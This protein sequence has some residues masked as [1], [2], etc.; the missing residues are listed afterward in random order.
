LSRLA[1]PCRR[2]K[3]PRHLAALIYLQLLSLRAF[4]VDGKLTFVKPIINLDDP[5]GKTVGRRTA[6]DPLRL[7]PSEKLAKKQWAD[8]GFFPA[9]RKGVYRFHTHEEA[10]EW[11]WKMMIRRKS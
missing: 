4:G 9:I 8:A 10:D 3:F 1:A 11:L 6:P 2:Q 5:V 7:A